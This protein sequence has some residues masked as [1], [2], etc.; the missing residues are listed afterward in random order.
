MNFDQI[1]KLLEA[2]AP[3]LQ[4]LIWPVIVVFLWR[5]FKIYVEDLRKDKN[6]SE[7]CIDVSASGL[8]FNFKKQV[9]VATMLVQADAAKQMENAQGAHPTASP[10][11]TEA[12][13]NTVSRVTNPVTAQRIAGATLLWV[14]D[15]PE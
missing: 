5:A 12:I 4:A 11:Q 8:K 7:M 9:E 14:D 13:V 15:R 2:I 10:A 1:I 3:F 6:V